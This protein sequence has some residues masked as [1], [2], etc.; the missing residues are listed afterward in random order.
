MERIARYMR[1]RF[2][3]GI[4]QYMSDSK[5]EECEPSGLYQQPAMSPKIEQNPINQTIPHHSRL[6]Q[7]QSPLSP[8]RT[9]RVS[10]KS[11]TP[12]LPPRSHPDP[13]VGKIQPESDSDDDSEDEE[14]NISYSN[15]F[16]TVIS[17]L[18]KKFA[19]SNE[20]QA[21]LNIPL[22]ENDYAKGSDDWNTLSHGNLNRSAS[23][24]EDSVYYQS[25]REKTLR[26]D[27]EEVEAF[28]VHSL[29]I[30]N[31]ENPVSLGIP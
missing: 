28:T 13:R 16:A 11:T 27:L 30:L 31:T 12:N 10:F 8:Q 5:T 21:P 3:E 25:Q 23:Y 24:D 14:G 17:D 15:N 1:Q 26:D 6:L 20:A 19:S 9:T 29:Y 22:D 7:H 2:P 4:P 18:K